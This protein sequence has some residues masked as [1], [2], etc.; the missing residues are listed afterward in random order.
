MKIGHILNK[1]KFTE[2]S[3]K[4]I[5]S[6]PEAD[7]NSRI[8]VVGQVKENTPGVTLGNREPHLREKNIGTFVEELKTFGN[9]FQNNEFLIET[10]HE[11]NEESYEFR[12][13][14]LTHIEIEAGE[15]VL[16]SNSGE[17]RELRESH[18]EP[19]LE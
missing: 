6:I 11:L 7:I 8:Y 9:N 14:K 17:L 5:C 19:E 2:E 15:V 3:A 10:L 4:L 18:Q 1:L 12:Y 13:H 16:K